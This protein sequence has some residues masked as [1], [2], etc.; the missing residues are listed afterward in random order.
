MGDSSAIASSVKG[1]LYQD[2]LIKPEEIIM[3]RQPELGGLGL[4]N[5]K[6]RSMAMLIHTFLSQAISSLFPANMYHNTLYRWH[7]LEQR[8]LPNPGRPPYYSSDFFSL[9]NDVHENTPLNVT[10]I[11]VKEWYR[12][13]L[14]MIHL[15]L[16]F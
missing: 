4:F 11:S 9:I 1:W 6:V 10:W 8:D 13:L 14:E 12:L 16:H 3:Y 2:M 5:V 7:V 15:H